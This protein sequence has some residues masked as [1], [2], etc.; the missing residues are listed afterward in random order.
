MN[1]LRTHIVIHESF[2]L[3]FIPKIVTRLEEAEAPCL[4]KNASASGS[5]KRQMLPISLPLPASAST[6]LLL[7]H[8]CSVKRGREAKIY[9][10]YNQFKTFLF[11]K[12]TTKFACSQNIKVI[13]RKFGMVESS[14]KETTFFISV[15]CTLRKFTSVSTSRP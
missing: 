9:K 6:S 15:S 8:C 13:C 12:N 2:M 11:Q 1:K 4:I 14:G 5:S 7:K 10:C 3:Y